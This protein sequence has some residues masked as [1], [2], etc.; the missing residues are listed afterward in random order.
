MYKDL[1]HRGY[2]LTSGLKY[3]GDYLVY[4]GHPHAVHSSH[5]AVVLSWKQVI[6]NLV[7]LGRLGAKVKKSVLL[8]SMNKSGEIQ[9]LTIQWNMA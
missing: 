3:G 6:A 8:C 9:Y 5:I 2:S 4:Q 1:W 7:S